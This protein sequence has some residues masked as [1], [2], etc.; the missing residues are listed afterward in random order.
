MPTILAPTYGARNTK[1]DWNTNMIALRRSIWTTWT[2]ATLG[3]AA[4]N[5]LTLSTLTGVCDL[6][7]WT[8]Q[9]GNVI[10]YD[11][12]SIVT[13]VQSS[14]E[15]FPSNLPIDNG[16][17]GQTLVVAG[18][19]PAPEFDDSGIVGAIEDVALIDQDISINNGSAIFSAR[20]KVRTG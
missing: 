17:P 8:V 18:L 4:L 15:Y 16:M 5:T 13:A 6:R 2:T 3:A 20:G 12:T 7:H 11:V 14:V 19:S 1:T 9:Q 10:A